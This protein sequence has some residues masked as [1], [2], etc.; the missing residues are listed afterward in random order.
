MSK[1][2]AITANDACKIIK[3]AGW[4]LVATKGSH[5]Q[6]KHPE[7]TGRV[8]IA[9]HGQ[10]QT[11]CPKTFASIMHQAGLDAEYEAF[12]HGHN[13][14]SKGS[15]VKQMIRQAASHQYIS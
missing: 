13:G 1:I 14:G 2:P 4:E 11:L 12:K 3:A 9:C 8:T 15:P 10:S 6:Y 7:Q 5:Q